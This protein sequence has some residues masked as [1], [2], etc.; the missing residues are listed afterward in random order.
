[1]ADTDK[2][3][4]QAKDLGFSY[5]G[6]DVISNLSLKIEEGIFYGLVGPNGCGKTTLLDLLLGARKPLEG[7]VLLKGK[8]LDK[9]S[10]RSLAREIA[11][12]PQEFKINF[13]FTVRE[14]IL[15]GRHPYIGR[16]S[17]PSGHDL[18]VVEEVMDRVELVPFGDRY[19]TELSGGEKQRVI[20]ARALA[21]Q[22][23]LLLLD[24]ATSNMDIYYTLLCLEHVRGR[25]RDEGL[26]VVA[27]FHDL[28]LAST[29]CDEIIF[30]RQGQVL[31][32]GP[33]DEV[34]TEDNVRHTFG[35][36]CHIFKDPFERR[37]QVMFIRGSMPS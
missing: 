20:F 21:Q 28:N 30:M 32:Q 12:V 34:L 4:L 3:I 8:G 7:S 36:D 25:V 14:I 19:I 16:I 24:E 6:K 35:V 22:T 23:P 10:R 15:M 18:G 17:T 9:Y 11:L 29:F 13:S 31:A 33:T 26:T 37:T 2:T 5:G 1:M 27:S